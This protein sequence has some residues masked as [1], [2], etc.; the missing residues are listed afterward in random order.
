MCLWIFAKYWRKG[1]AISG[2]R[3]FVVHTKRG[4]EKPFC[5][6]AFVLPVKEFRPSLPWVSSGS[7]ANLFC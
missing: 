2:L 6:K 4:C 5:N 3:L 7:T 1:K